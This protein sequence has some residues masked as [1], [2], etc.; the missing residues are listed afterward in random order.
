MVIKKTEG[1]LIMSAKENENPAPQNVEKPSTQKPNPNVVPPIYDV[2]T[3]GYDP[4]KI[5][6]RGNDKKK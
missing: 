3:E 4:S 5:E 6:K 1:S 2:V